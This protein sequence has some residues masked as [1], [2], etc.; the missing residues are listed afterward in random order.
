MGK[1]LRVQAAG[2]RMQN[3]VDTVCYRMGPIVGPRF[4][5]NVMASLG[6][7]L[8]FHFATTALD[9]AVA[10]LRLLVFE[11]HEQGTTDKGDDA[12]LHE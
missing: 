8:P 7:V 6:A 3:N 2:S 9:W 10:L 4:S 1:T 11:R 5:V 12:N